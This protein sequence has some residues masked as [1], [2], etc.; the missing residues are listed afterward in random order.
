MNRAETADRLRIW[1]VGR[2]YCRREAGPLN[3]AT[4]LGWYSHPCEWQRDHIRVR[5]NPGGI[6]I[7][8]DPGCTIQISRSCG[9]R[10]EEFVSPNAKRID[11]CAYGVDFAYC[12][13]AIVAFESH[14]AY[15]IDEARRHFFAE[16]G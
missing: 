3:P 11:F 4:G 1:L 7:L 6:I 14:P 15:S 2:G 10:R 8:R 9:Q 12:Q 5:I 16:V 13:N